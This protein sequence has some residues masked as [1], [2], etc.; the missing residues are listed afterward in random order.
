MAGGR[1]LAWGAFGLSEAL[2]EVKNRYPKTVNCGGDD[3]EL[4]LL[5]GVDLDTAKAFTDRLTDYDLLSMNRDIQEPKV[6][7]AWSAAIDK[8]NIIS[9]GAR[10]NGEIIG[11]TAV[12]LEPNSWS[13]HV[14]EMRILIQPDARDIGLGRTL[15]QESFLIGLDLGLEK[16]TVRMTL[17]QEGAI[18]VFEEMGFKTEALLRDHVKDR[19]GEKHDLL[20]LSHD[21][22]GVSAKMQAYGMGEAFD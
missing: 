13:A 10:R 8:G 16:L 11:T 12:V 21:V 19:D 5:N 20:M 6:L 22:E 2:N 1:Q 18:A 3:I 7:A 17:D 9:V 15:I 4:D 14:G